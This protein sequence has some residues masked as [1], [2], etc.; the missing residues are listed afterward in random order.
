MQIQEVRNPQVTLSSK[1]R[2]THRGQA[3]SYC[4]DLT[5]PTVLKLRT[6]HIRDY[7]RT[8]HQPGKEIIGFNQ[9]SKRIQITV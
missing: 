3:L 8:S 4:L 1:Q 2:V 7:T 9:H 6:S 5:L